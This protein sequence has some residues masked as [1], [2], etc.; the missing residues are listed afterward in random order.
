MLYYTGGGR[1]PLPRTRRS[2]NRFEP[3]SSSLH[4]FLLAPALACAVLCPSL[5]L[6]A[7]DGARTRPRRV[8]APTP[9]AQTPSQTYPEAEPPATRLTAEPSIR[10]G[11]STNA[12]S[13]TVSTTGRL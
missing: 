8:G 12:R 3:M 7:Q 4:R 9:E 2:N 10:I 5:L 6:R 13:V 1:S 11:L